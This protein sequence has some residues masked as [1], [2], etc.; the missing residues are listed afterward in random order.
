MLNQKN[1]Y[2]HTTKNSTLLAESSMQHTT[3]GLSMVITVRTSTPSRY[4]QVVALQKAI[5]D[6]LQ[7]PVSLKVNQ[8]IA[9]RLDPLIPPTFTPTPTLAQTNTPGPNPTTTFTQIPPTATSTSVPTVTST[10]GLVQVINATLPQLKLY[11]SPNGPVIGK[12]RLEQTL[13]LLYNRQETGGIIWVQVL[14]DEGR[15]GWIP[16]YYLIQVTRTPNQ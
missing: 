12:L 11:Q 10:P 7:Q 2:E 9:E 14:D 4:E 6:D 3:S 13:T 15:L 16:E 8:V 1:T 5:V